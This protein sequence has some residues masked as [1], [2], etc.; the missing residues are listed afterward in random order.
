MR[1][2]VISNLYPPDVVGGYELLCSHAVEGLRRRGH[3]ITVLTTSP[4]Q[5]PVVE[6]E[7]GVLRRLELI[8]LWNPHVLARLGDPTLTL[9]RSRASF[10]VAHNLHTLLATLDEVE[11]DAVFFWNL[12]GLGGLA[13]AYAV[14][15][16]GYPWVWE[17]MDCVPR[18]LC[19]FQEQTV[20]W[21]ADE[22]NR[23][24]RGRYMAVSRGVV[25]ETTAAGISLHD[26]VSILPVWVRIPEAPPTGRRYHRPGEPLRMVF[27]SA[28]THAKGVDVALQAAR[29]L[30]QDG[31]GPFTL[32]L[33]G[34]AVEGRIEDRIAAADVAD[35]VTVHGFRPQA[36]LIASYVDY[37]VFVFPT[38]AREPF[39][40]APMEAAAQGCV[41]IFSDDCGNAE[42]LVDGVHCL[43]AQRD[44]RAFADRLA[45]VMRGEEDLEA[46]GRRASAVVRRDFSGG[47]VILR[48]ERVLQAA[49][50]EGRRTPTHDSRSLQTLGLYADN[51][52]RFLVPA[53]ATYGRHARSVITIG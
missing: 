22:F 44:P 19:S 29:L 36:E 4:R 21:L 42:W 26:E 2:L 9:Q 25:D 40:A 39:A 6:P 52:L 47:R 15:S 31:A 43:K 28:L 13:L 12:M 48:M 34:Q 10:V 20:P 33:F 51:L 14:Q 46:I 38:H 16:L 1:I 11:P 50:D 8:D 17:L 35:C 37:D 27:A 3:D 30:K 53:A 24:M 7:V 5:V 49:V 18:M 45:R 23:H 32:D 41:P